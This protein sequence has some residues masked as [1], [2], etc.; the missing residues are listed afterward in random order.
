ML[1]E[2]LCYG[3]EQMFIELPV[4]TFGNPNEEQNMI[5]ACVVVIR[6]LILSNVVACV[7]RPC[8][9]LASAHLHHEVVSDA[10]GCQNIP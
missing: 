5:N 9:L 4:V 8:F 3:S 2:V 6:H 10:V 7:S 1:V